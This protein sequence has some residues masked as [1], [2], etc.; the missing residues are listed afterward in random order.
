MAAH[1]ATLERLTNGLWAVTLRCGGS[2]VRLISGSIE[3]LTGKSVLRVIAART[4][5]VWPLQDPVEYRT[6]NGQLAIVLRMHEGIPE[7]L[8]KNSRALQLGPDKKLHPD[9]IWRWTWERSSE[10]PG[11]GRLTEAVQ[12]HAVGPRGLCATCRQ[13]APCKTLHL[14]SMYFIDLLIN[15]GEPT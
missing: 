4:Q 14:L 2:G 13:K 11:T 15:M 7:P 8:P 6:P 12:E 10:T 9:E 1:Q 3:H 5:S